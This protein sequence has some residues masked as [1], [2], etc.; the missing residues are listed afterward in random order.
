MRA[1]RTSVP[2]AALAL[3]TLGL[4]AG[5]S[6]EA[7]VLARVGNQTI[8]EEDFAAAAEQLAHRY[9]VPPDSAKVLLLRDLVDREVLVQG[10][11]REGAYHDTAFL[12]LGRILEEEAMRQRYYAQ[13]GAT[14]VLVSDDEVA[15]LH[16]WRSE[17]RWVRLVYAYTEPLAKAALAELRRGADFASV[18]DR[19]NP[20]G[21][22][23]PGG[24]LGYV[25]PGML[26]LPLDDV[27]RTAP[28][29]RVLGPIE[30][31]GQGWFLV[32]VQERRTA[33]RVP[34]K[35]ERAMLVSILRQRKQ[36]QVLL[37]ELERLREAYHVRLVRGAGQELVSRIQ[38]YALRG[39]NPPELTSGEQAVA[40]VRFDGGPF[41][42]GDAFQ[43]L[44]TGQFQRPNFN[45]LPTVERWLEVRAL[46]RATL[47][48][49][50]RR[51]LHQDPD[52]RRMVRERLN[53]YLIEGYVNREVTMR[54][55][56]SDDDVR[57]VFRMAGLAPQRL[58]QARFLAVTLRDSATAAQLAA[59]APQA[60]GLREAV[61]TAALGVPV[62]SHT[63][64]FPD[65]AMWGPLE[66]TFM[67]VEPGGYAGPVQAA[68]GWMVFQLLAKSV[69]PVS[70]ES[71]PP[72]TRAMLESQARD[73]KRGRM[74][75]ALTDS[76][77]RVIPTA[78]Y[79]ERLQRLPWPS[80]A[81]PP[82]FSPAQ[83]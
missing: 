47:I 2:F 3:L 30:T 40:L 51:L 41:T 42:M 71:L 57:E 12:D 79:R 74:L 45:V 54:A 65:E 34:L 46:E 83:G 22:V 23:P 75:Q 9:P 27:V 72:S 38:P 64:R 29:G 6:P 77:R 13:L 11:L 21:Q 56:V 55:T 26:P 39:E 50:R 44:R 68:G 5:C 62:R 70:F 1:P 33:E 36:R 43:E 48:E 78:E 35:T 24:D 16:R 63:A 10:A 28:I 19:F 32:W 4:F 81:M 8:R 37:R 76:L 20:P 25:S 49:A 18:A 59:T 17:E 58:E 69:V 73:M 80:P 61:A 60:G 52:V 31:V 7:G 14:Q 15:E 66:P 82:G 67:A 53:D